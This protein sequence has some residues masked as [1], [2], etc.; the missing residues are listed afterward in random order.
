ML[1]YASSM[2]AVT[3]LSLLR[4]GHHTP[5]ACDP[6]AFQV[7]KRVIGAVLHGAIEAYPLDEKRFAWAKD[8][9]PLAMQCH[10]ASRPILVTEPLIDAHRGAADRTHDVPSWRCTRVATR[11]GV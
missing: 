11:S 4:P 3:P 8:A 6:L 5:P 1:S 10:V 7:F 9:F 2:M